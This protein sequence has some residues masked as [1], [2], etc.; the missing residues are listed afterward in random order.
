MFRLE[1]HHLMLVLAFLM[2]HATALAQDGEPLEALVTVTASEGDE[3]LVE[4]Y[5]R[6]EIRSL[7]DVNIVS[8]VNDV[9]VMGFELRVVAMRLNNLNG[10]HTGYVL[11]FVH[12]LHRRDQIEPIPNATQDFKDVWYDT[13]M[14]FDESFQ[15]HG[16][17][18]VGAD[19]L[20]EGCARVVAA[21]DTDL[22]EIHRGNEDVRRRQRQRLEDEAKAMREA[23]R[24]N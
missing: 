2:V 20:Q 14:G 6:R 13:E 1:M 5:L 10:L 11:S 7:G 16:V 21:F 22:L 18:I 15:G 12:L 17:Q 3:D 23:F 4:S 19:D 8:D 24:D 9:S